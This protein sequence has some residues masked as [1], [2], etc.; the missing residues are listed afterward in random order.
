MPQNKKDK[1][2][3][4]LVIVTIVS[5]CFSI[6]SGAWGLYTS[7]ENNHLKDSYQ[8]Q[9]TTTKEV[10]DKNG[11]LIKTIQNITLSYSEMNKSKDSTIQRLLVQLNQKDVAKIKENVRYVYLNSTIR[12]S[13]KSVSYIKVPVSD[14]VKICKTDTVLIAV[15]VLYKDTVQKKSGLKKLW[16]KIF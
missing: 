7:I 9:C 12:D 11:N 14:T 2:N 3:K 10:V 1:A 8:I 5:M 6:L 4:I 15:P 13:S 16:N